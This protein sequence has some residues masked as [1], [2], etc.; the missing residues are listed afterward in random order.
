MCWRNSFCPR[1]WRSMLRLFCLALLRECPFI[2]RRLCQTCIGYYSYG[3]LLCA[4]VQTICYFCFVRSDESG[5]DEGV[6]ES[7]GLTL[8]MP[9]I[10]VSCVCKLLMNEIQCM[11]CI[12][13]SIYLF[14]TRL[15]SNQLSYFCECWRPIQAHMWEIMNS[16]DFSTVSVLRLTKSS[17]ASGLCKKK[18]GIGRNFFLWISSCNDLFKFSD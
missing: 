18:S 9:C 8:C 17:F 15:P 3:M 7:F 13:F 2:T 6:R 1:Q 14:C 11:L 5:F 10:F 12:V 4:V 16:F